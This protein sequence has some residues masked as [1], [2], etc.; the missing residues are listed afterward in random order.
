MI[1]SE[2]A[3]PLLERVIAGARRRVF[4]SFRIFDTRTQLRND[5]ARNAAGG[6]DWA[7]LLIT[8]ASKGVDVRLQV[9]DFDPIGGADL[10]R[11]AWA[12]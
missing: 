6:E 10:H 8:L 5:E 12:S 4:L 9:S 1:T 7:A 11:D 3:Y 2:E